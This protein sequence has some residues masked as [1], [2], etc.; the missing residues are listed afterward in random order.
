[1]LL[2]LN[3]YEASNAVASENPFMFIYLQSADTFVSH[4]HPAGR[5]KKP[6]LPS[7]ATA[8][9]EGRQAGSDGGGL[10]NVWVGQ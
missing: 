7:T 3:M 8:M 5:T 2:L 9:G 4:G 10:S 6:A 1:L